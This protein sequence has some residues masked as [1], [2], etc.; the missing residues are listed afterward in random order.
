MKKPSYSQMR[1]LF[2]DAHVQACI[3]SRKAGVTSTPYTLK[4][5]NAK[6][7]EALQEVISALD[8]P[9]LLENILDTPFF[10]FQPIEIFW[11]E[12]GD[13]LFG[14]VPSGFEAKPQ[15]WFSLGKDGEI[16]L[17][18]KSAPFDGEA[19]LPFKFLCPI[20]RKS[21]EKP[22]GE[23]LF[24]S[25]FAPVN[26]KRGAVKF[27]GTFVEKYGMPWAL[28]TIPRQTLDSEAIKFKE[29]LENMVQ[30]GVAVYDDSCSVELVE[31]GSKQGSSAVY[32]DF[33]SFQNDEI[34]K[35]ILGQTLTTEVQGSGSYA[36]GRVHS[37]VRDDILRGDI[38]LVQNAIN[39]LIGYVLAVNGIEEGAHFEFVGEILVQQ[40]RAARDK[41]L[42]DAG[43][44]FSKEYF[45]RTYGFLEGDFLGD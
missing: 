20:Y 31:S 21:T 11:E 30:D 2:N 39:T 24:D 27:W 4:S 40:E 5:N 8:F 44:K 34:S 6:L 7:S 36:L 35:A 12:S 9:T 16:R 41:V 23:A 18:T 22:F 17:R 3:N 33:I 25:V 45:M 43:V 14:L 19:L 1:N 10:G 32:R 29:A 28:G 42:S 13:G 15:E 37:Q 26:F 38:K